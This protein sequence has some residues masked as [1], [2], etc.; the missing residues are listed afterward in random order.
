M[1]CIS[2]GSA[3]GA[4]TNPGPDARASPAGAGAVT[5][6]VNGDPGT[7]WP[8]NRTDNVC[9]AASTGLK[10]TYKSKSLVKILQIGRS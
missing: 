3:L 4:D 7:A 1:I 8:L 2:A 9:G 6:H 10:F 5:V